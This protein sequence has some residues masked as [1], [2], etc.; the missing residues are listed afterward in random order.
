MAA[1]QQQHLISSVLANSYQFYTSLKKKKK[2]K[3]LIQ[4]C[5]QDLKLIYLLVPL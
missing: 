3:S 1:G 5:H 2:E 4:K